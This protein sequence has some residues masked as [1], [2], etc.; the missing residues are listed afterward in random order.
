M[1]RRAY[2]ARRHNP[3]RKPRKKGIPIW[4]LLLGA[5]VAYVAYAVLSGKAGAAN[6]GLGG[7]AGAANLGLGG[8][9]GSVTPTPDGDLGSN[10]SPQLNNGG[11]T[12][13]DSDPTDLLQN[14]AQSS[15]LLADSLDSSP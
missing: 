13:N 7:K 12:T 6:L 4:K 5:S 15:S 8:S 14:G 1:T 2:R 10:T 11:S 9:G 3:S